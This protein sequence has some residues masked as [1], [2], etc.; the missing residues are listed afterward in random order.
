MDRWKNKKYCSLRC[1]W[2]SHKKKVQTKVCIN[3]GKEFVLSRRFSQKVNDS[4]QYCGKS[5]AYLGSD[6]NKK[7]SSARL[8]KFTGEQNGKWKGGIQICNGY[9]RITKGS[10]RIHRIVM[11]KHLGR[12]LKQDEVIHH[13]NGDKLDNRIENLELMTFETHSRHHALEKSIHR[14]D[15]GKFT[16]KL[17]A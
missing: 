7:I 2:D 8:G 6:R 10:K 3:C 5:C 11:E 12:E 1:L 4:R 9:A 13:I 17:C 16:K 15:K 14:D